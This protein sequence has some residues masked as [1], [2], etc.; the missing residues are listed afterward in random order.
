MNFGWCP[1]VHLTPQV[2]TVGL[3][4]ARHNIAE[5][6]IPVLEPCKLNLILVFSMHRQSILFMCQRVF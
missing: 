3:L 5:P 1:R 6:G 4:R 2:F